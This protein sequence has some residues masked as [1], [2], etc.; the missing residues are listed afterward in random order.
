MAAG[1]KPSLEHLTV[2]QHE[3]PVV[4]SYLK[5]VMAEGNGKK[6]DLVVKYVTFAEKLLSANAGMQPALAL[7]QGIGC[8]PMEMAPR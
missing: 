2:P 1:V 7:L 6:K 4:G 8:I 3:A 5:K